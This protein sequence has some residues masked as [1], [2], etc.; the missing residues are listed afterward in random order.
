MPAAQTAVQRR[1]A[2]ACMLVAA[3]LFA[4][5]AGLSHRVDHAA[6]MSAASDGHDSDTGHSC[7]AFDAAAVADAIHLPPFAAPLQASTRILA[8]WAAFA[9]WDAPPVLHFSSR[10]PPLS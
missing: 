1:A 2:I 9:S 7:A 6:Y 5:W 8:L 10:A 4:Q 3:L